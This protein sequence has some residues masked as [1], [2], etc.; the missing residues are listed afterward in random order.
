MDLATKKIHSAMESL[1]LATNNLENGNKRLCVGDLDFAESKVFAAKMILINQV[2]D[3][4][5]K[6]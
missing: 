5:G 2:K 4:E 6:F 3:E 1:Q